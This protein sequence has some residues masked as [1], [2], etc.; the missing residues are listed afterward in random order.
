MANPNG[1]INVNPDLVIA[2]E[3]CVR[4]AGGTRIVVI[5]KAYVDFQNNAGVN[6]ANNHAFEFGLSGTVYIKNSSVVMPAD[7]DTFDCLQTA[8]PGC[9]WRQDVLVG[10]L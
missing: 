5:G 6:K 3:K 8:C 4:E 9:A 1:L 10:N 2:K 7:P